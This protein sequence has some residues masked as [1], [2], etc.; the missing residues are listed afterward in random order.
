MFKKANNN[1]VNNAIFRLSTRRKKARKPLN[2]PQI[3]SNHPISHACALGTNS[4][5][6]STQIDAKDAPGTSNRRT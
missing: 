1:N 4:R 6:N 2:L 3:L 5:A